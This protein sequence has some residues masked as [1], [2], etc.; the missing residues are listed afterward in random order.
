MSDA[1]YT[2]ECMF[3]QHRGWYHS[4]QLDEVETA[5]LYFERDHMAA[6][7]SLVGGWT[8]SCDDDDLEQIVR[9]H[10]RRQP[11]SSMPVAFAAVVAGHKEYIISGPRDQDLHPEE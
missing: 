9:T 4:C 3:D 6:N 11:Y 10:V 2:S 8:V 7:G 5:R 1:T